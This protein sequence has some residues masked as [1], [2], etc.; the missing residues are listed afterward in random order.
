MLIG[1]LGAGRMGRGLGSAWAG[2]GLEVALGSRDP[3]EARSRVGEVPRL[4]V[5]DLA[6]AAAAPVVVLATP[7]GVTT[8]LLPRLADLLRGKVVVDI[9]NPFGAAP[10]GRSGLWVHQEALG[11]PATWVAAFKTNFAATVGA[12]DFVVRQ[13]LIASD[14]PEALATTADLAR[15]A[16]FAPLA[17]GGLDVA[18]ALDLMVPLML[19]LDRMHGTGA[20]RSHWRFVA[21]H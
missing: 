9:T 11:V 1:V 6:T 19:S 21:E 18:P 2:S 3:Q 20:G 15:R 10:P 7:F 5:T 17:C 13:C 14:D 16:G 4:Q 8:D 12:P